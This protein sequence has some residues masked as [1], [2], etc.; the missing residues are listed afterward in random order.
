MAERDFYKVLGVPRT[1][2]ESEIRKAYRN[3]ARKY[4]PDKN[5]GNHE[6]EE[7]FKSVAHASEVL[8]NK[9]KRELYDEFGEMGLKEGF[10]PDAFRQYR[11]GGGGP[12][13]VGGPD[14]T[15]FEDILNNLR[16]AGRA[17][18]GFAGFQDFMGG[19]TVQEL[20]KRG[21][22]QQRRPVAA[23]VVSEISLGFVDALR[24]G[25]RE[26]QLAIPGEPNA[27]KLKVRIPSGVRDGGQIRLRGQGIEGGDA[28]LRIRVDDHEHFRR[29]GDDL[30]LNLPVTVGEAYNGAKVGVPTLDGE[31]SLTIPRG[32]KSGTKLRLRGKGAPKSDGAGD[33]IVTLMIR[34]PD[35]SDEEL[36]KHVNEIE[37][38]YTGSPRGEIRL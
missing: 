5:P 13:G 21:A 34:L 12:G 27:R 15:D 1:A 37:K 10:N 19:E 35:A 8:L 4:H 16:G 9:K 29:D 36:E 14:I 32:A 33:L 18:G 23:D 20:F 26:I 38:R 2:T 25:E 11:R 28:V 31:V 7:K 30:L 17:S 24:G 6:A 3:L 22:R